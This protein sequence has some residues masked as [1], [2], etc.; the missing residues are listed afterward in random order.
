MPTART[1]KNI[2]KSP[3]GRRIEVRRSGVH[4]QGV[5]ALRALA[6][7]EK[8]I[9]YKGEIISWAQ[10][11]ERHPHD[12]T[13]PNHTFYFHIESGDVI[14]GHV[15]GN[16]ARWINHACEPNCEAAEEGC[17][18]FIQALRD[19]TVGEELVYNYGLTLDARYTAKLKKEFEC[20]CGAPSCRKTM[21]APKEKSK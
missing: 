2:S 17:R 16:M 8:I 14:D 12:P 18:V 7:G 9:E 15:N 13:Q 4:G 20:R 21:L 6:V 11:L 10:A 5:F 1:A 3:R 19:I